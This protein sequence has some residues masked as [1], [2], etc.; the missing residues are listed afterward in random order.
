M[1]KALFTKPG[2]RT[3]VEKKKKPYMQNAN[4]IT[5]RKI[6]FLVYKEMLLQHMCRPICSI[7]AIA[8]A[9]HMLTPLLESRG[10][11]PREGG[12]RIQFRET[13][14]RAMDTGSM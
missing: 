11:F 8:G 7:N 4:V 13:G 12:K 10:V 3:D 2:I 6:L 9:G 1:I 14:E 5:A